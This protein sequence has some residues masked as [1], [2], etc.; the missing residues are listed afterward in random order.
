MS[1][2]EA[3]SSNSNLIIFSLIILAYGI[4]KWYLGYAI[5]PMK[6]DYN[7]KKKRVGKTVPPYPNGWYIACKGNLVPK[8]GTRAIDIAGQNIVVARDKDGKAHALY[9]YCTHMGAHLGVGGQVVSGGC[10]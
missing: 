4:Y 2:L 9:A 8:N 1:F 6:G 5:V 7:T 3:L 10:L